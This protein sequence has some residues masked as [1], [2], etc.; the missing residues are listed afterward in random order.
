M[1]P[2]DL[3]TYLQWVSFQAAHVGPMIGQLRHFK[4]FAERKLPYAIQ[5][6]ERETGRIP[7]VLDSVDLSRTS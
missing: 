5:R 3:Y 7:R 1:K 6:Y 4:V 2:I